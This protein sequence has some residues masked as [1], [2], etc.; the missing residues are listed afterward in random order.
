MK[1]SWEDTRFVGDGRRTIS[2]LV[3]SGFGLIGVG[4]KVRIASAQEG[5]IQFHRRGYTG[6]YDK[7]CPVW[8]IL[9]YCRVKDVKYYIKNKRVYLTKKQEGGENECNSS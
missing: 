4:R 3:G 1:P 5:I 6:L 7:D 2:P 8:V 9:E